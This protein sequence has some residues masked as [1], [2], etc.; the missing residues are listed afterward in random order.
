MSIRVEAIITSLVFDH[1]LRIR[2]KAEATKAPDELSQAGDDTV[3][4]SANDNVEDDDNEDT[5]TLH[6]RAATNVSNV[7]AS[8]ETSATS[9][10]MASSP[11][12]KEGQKG[13]VKGGAT[14]P[15]TKSTNNL[16]GKI[17]NLVTSDLVNITSGLDFLFVGELGF[18]RR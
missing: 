12:H 13:S 16:V 6:S 10:A 4:N 2:L 5:E 11:E 3:S 8:A 7:S 9:T 1:A 18:G 17:N 14:K 15:E